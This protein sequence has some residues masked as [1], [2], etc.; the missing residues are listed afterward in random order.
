MTDYIERKINEAKKIEFDDDYE[1]YENYDADTS[2]TILTDFLSENYPYIYD[3]MESE[4]YVIEEAL[5]QFFQEIVYDNKV[6]GFYTYEYI[7]EFTKHKLSINEF[8]V[9]PEYRGNKIF[10]N[11]L[12]NLIAHN[13]YDGVLLRNPSKLIINILLENQL[14]TRFSK[15][16]VRTG[17]KLAT[18]IDKLLKNKK[19]NKL[20][21]DINEN[22]AQMTYLGNIYDMNLNSIVFNDTLEIISPHDE[23]VFLSNP[24]SYDYQRYHLSKKIRNVDKRYVKNIY[25]TIIKSWDDLNKFQENVDKQFLENVGIDLYLGSLD[26]PNESIQML[27]DE[28][29]LTTSQLES[30]REKIEK[31]LECNEITPD[32]I[33]TR[34]YYLIDYPDKDALVTGSANIGNC[35][36]CDEYEFEEGVCMICGYNLFEKKIE[37]VQKEINDYVD[38]ETGVYKSLI[39]TINEK[40]LDKDKTIADQIEIS[41]CQMLNFLNQINDYPSLPDFDDINEV[42]EEKYI[43]FLHENAYIEIKENT[44]KNDEK[45]F[46]EMLKE[47]GEI[48][49]ARAYKAHMHRDY[50]YKITKKG[51]KYYLQNKIFNLYMEKI[52]NL[53]YYQFKQLYQENINTLKTD[54]IISQ[55][56]RQV[57]KQTIEDENL[58]GYN[59]VCLTKINIAKDDDEKMFL[60]YMIKSLI[61]RLNYYRLSINDDNFMQTPLDVYNE[62]FLRDCED[63]IYD[64]DY[65]ELYE[66]AYNSIEMDKLKINK[67][68]L[69]GDIE[70]ILNN[71]DMPTT[72]Q[73]LAIKYNNI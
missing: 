18:R 20:Y 46:L 19:I 27:I 65:D 67:N 52:I 23:I 62:I 56:I 12:K 43:E 35:P 29:E 60:T 3:A 68:E 15:N 30:I 50:K 11:T 70:D 2:H 5:C 44:N 37:Q 22:V 61:C 69:Y 7:S 63:L 13:E 71:F 38:P 28:G 36:Y 40:S 49:S 42:S 51:R 64:Y 73:K 45:Q 25:K 72:N 55:Y 8:Y 4:K 58:I 21:Y 53:P 24:R 41:A 26:K 59:N 16:L 57:E 66:N 10:I 31:A 17:I 14:A 33:L 9:V 34:F 47:S 54:E 32:K 6:V 39:N 48:P 1:M